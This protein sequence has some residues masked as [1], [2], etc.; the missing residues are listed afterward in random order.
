MTKAERLKQ[1]KDQEKIYKALDRYFDADWREFVKGV[2]KENAEANAELYK[3][4]VNI[5]GNEFAED[6]KS[7]MKEIKHQFALL[8]IV[9]EPAGMELK[10]SRYSTI[11][12]IWVYQ[13]SGSIYSAEGYK[14]S[15]CIQLADDR[16]IRIEYQN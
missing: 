11:P 16:W 3:V 5:K 8:T 15:L 12:K 2:R 1:L 6:V 13:K 4:I 7:F 10:D 9:T 14:G